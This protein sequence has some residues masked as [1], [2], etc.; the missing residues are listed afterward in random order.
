MLQNKEKVVA[1]IIARGGSK[2]IPRK[3]VLPLHGKPLVAWPIDLAKSIDRIDRVIIS[4]DD[5]EIMAIAK[6]H[7]AEALFKRPAEL[8]DDET[9][10]LPVLRHCIN[11]LE[12]KENYKPD[13]ILLLYPTAPFLK[14]E[15]IEKALDLFANTRCNS[16]ISVVKDWGRFWRLDQNINKHIPFYP[17]QRVNRQYYQP[18]Y[19]E[20]GAIYFS[21]YDVLMKMNRA[22]DDENIEFLIMKEGE[23]IDIDN[24]S[25]FAK[26][27]DKNINK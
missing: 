5:E 19:R 21:R 23:N 15:R 8:A 26:A 16:V 27:E 20:D 2:S 18:L 17:K 25:D 14:K 9:P 3:N 13:I 12:E 10:T 11:Y 6:E 22:V 7:G 24:P 1:I 4:T